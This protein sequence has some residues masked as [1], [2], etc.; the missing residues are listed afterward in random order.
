MSIS[1]LNPEDFYFAIARG[2]L[3]GINY[4]HKF[5]RNPDIDTSEGF[6]AV[7]NGGG[8]YTGFNATAAETVEVFSS[9]GDDTS[10]GTGA[11]TV[12]LF[13]LDGDYLEIN[14]TVTLNGATAVDTVNTYLRLSRAIVRS[15]GSGGENAGDITV[16]QKTT[17]ANVFCA[18]PTGYNQTMI[19]A[20]TVPAGK[21]A[22][23]TSWFAC[24]SRKNNALSQVKMLM[25][26]LDEVFHVKE[27]F[28]VA[29]TGTSYIL[30][31]YQVP[32]NSITAKTDIKIMA[33]TSV[34]NNGVAAGFDLILIDD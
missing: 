24:L 1:N 13:G 12:E 3:S 23:I 4:V 27:E 19:A 25:R 28:T 14:E 31:E 7:W 5:G 10:A 15:A 32:K 34:N 20:Y 18:V 33:D 30:R 26:P 22:F 11:R 29:Y 8:D 6:E 16:R 9:D 17:T 2:N 21:T